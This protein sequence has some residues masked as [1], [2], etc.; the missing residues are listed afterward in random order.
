MDEVNEDAFV[1]GLS[2]Y[3][4]ENGGVKNI[5]NQRCPWELVLHSDALHGPTA[6]SHLY[7]KL[8]AELRDSLFNLRQR[9]RA[10]VFRVAFSEQITGCMRLARLGR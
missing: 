8:L 10:V 9:R 3:A 5:V 2:A 1:I 4:D 6:D 7:A